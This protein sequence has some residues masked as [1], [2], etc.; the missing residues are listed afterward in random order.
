[1]STYKSVHFSELTFCGGY[2][3]IKIT[4]DTHSEVDYFISSRVVSLAPYAFD[5]ISLEEL[6][7]F[8]NIF[9]DRHNLDLDVYSDDELFEVIKHKIVRWIQLDIE[10]YGIPDLTFDDNAIIEEN[11]LRISGK[12]RN[13]DSLEEYCRR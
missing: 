8:I 4:I 5:R 13:I 3:S 11:F 6:Y 10:G 9:V 1:M 2:P 12:C 7:N